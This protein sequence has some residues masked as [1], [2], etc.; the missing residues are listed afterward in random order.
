MINF[1]FHTPRCLPSRPK[2]SKVLQNVASKIGSVLCRSGN[3]DLKGLLPVTV[4][5]GFLGAGKTTLL[6]HILKNK[7]GTRAAVLVNDMADVNID[8]ALIS[9]SIHLSG[10]E[11]LVSL[12]NGC[13]CC[14]IRADLIKEVRTLALKQ[15]FDCLIVESTGVSLPLPVAA[16]FG[17]SSSELGFEE[18]ESSEEGSH[19]VE[20]REAES[21]LS[22]VAKLDSLI[23]VVDAQRFVAN[24]LESA[25]LQA[26]GLAVDE[27]DDRT[28]ADLL[29]EQVEFADLLVLNKVDLV[30]T[31]QADQ[32]ELLLRKLNG[33][34]KIIRS[35]YGSVPVAEILGTG[36]FDVEAVKHSPGWLHELNQFEAAQRQHAK[37]HD[38][39]Q[40]NHGRADMRT[41]AHASAESSDSGETE[42]HS[43]LK[44]E[45]TEAERFGISSFVYYA[46][47]PFH[48]SRLLGSA[49]SV[50]W[51]G[52]LRTKGF[53][54]LATRH[55]VMG[56][57]QSAGGSWQGE[58]G[59]F[60]EASLS[61]HE[62]DSSFIDD[63]ATATWDPVWG[64]RN[65]LDELPEWITA[66]E[67]QK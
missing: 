29:I 66:E 6:Q 45:L 23:T 46:R 41:R 18:V 39:E 51:E 17:L 5:S 36:R 60:W 9:G 48:P 42:V 61:G 43:K 14:S 63:Q 55:D 2:R 32:V 35:S 50:S 56:I 52:V 20:T 3:E 58:P 19:S 31:G 64:D 22:D 30:T 1:K 28:V 10:G 4:L 27:F 33:S 15:C 13:I 44:Y 11:T 67:E 49:L 26:Q 57:W 8:E 21:S 54:W 59:G 25:P 34:A 65:F 37:M 38:H 53:F 12:S 24:V 47:R 7:E 62:Q 16:S 40:H